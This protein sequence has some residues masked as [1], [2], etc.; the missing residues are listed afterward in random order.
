MAICNMALNEDNRVTLR[1]Y[2]EVIT[3]IMHGHKT[4]AEVDTNDI[5]TYIMYI[6]CILY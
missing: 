3:E 6:I 4:N 2:I 1:N 5:I